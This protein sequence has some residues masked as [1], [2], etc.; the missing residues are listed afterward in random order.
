ML[1]TPPPQ[2]RD[3]KLSCAWHPPQHSP[4]LLCTGTQCDGMEPG[5]CPAGNLPAS[6]SDSL[7]AAHSHLG[8]VTTCPPRQQLGAE[9]SYSKLAVL[10]HGFPVRPA[11]LL[12]P[13][14]QVPLT[15]TPHL[16]PSQ[17]SRRP[18]LLTANKHEGIKALQ[19]SGPC[20]IPATC[21]QNALAS[22]DSIF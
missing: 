22:Q 17:P 10:V 19:E 8:R 15:H 2:P 4:S 6:V 21:Y 11:S 16:H 14:P 3:P 7:S 9:R 12:S 13:L 18:L 1:T 20:C 5:L